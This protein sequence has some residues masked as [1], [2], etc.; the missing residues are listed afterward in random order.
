MARTKQRAQHS[1]GDWSHYPGRNCY[2][3][4]LVPYRAQTLSRTAYRNENLALSFLLPPG[5]SES[6]NPAL[7][8]KQLA[9]ERCLDLSL[10]RTL[11]LE[12]RTR[13]W[14]MVAQEERV[15]S[16]HTIKTGGLRAQAPAILHVCSESRA[17]GLK[18]YCLSFNFD[19]SWEMIE[20]AAR[21]STR[22]SSYFSRV[23]FNFDHDILYFAEGW[24]ENVD[25]EWSCMNHLKRLLD[26]DDMWR[27][28]RI[29][30]DLVTSI[31]CPRASPDEGP[32]GPYLAPWKGLKKLYLGLKDPGLDPNERVVSK[33]LEVEHQEEFLQQ[34]R[35]SPK[36]R[37]VS[38]DLSPEQ[39][40]DFIKISTGRGYGSRFGV[41]QPDLADEF[42]ERV[43]PVLVVNP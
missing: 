22:N 34:Y 37:E 41:I 10:F 17:V 11:P 38:E 6:E 43:C 8:K 39:A 26:L 3:K 33:E 27:V 36:W 1:P 40:L 35:A 18:H 42:C 9:L 28:E 4:N 2:E 29:G 13:I 30:F 32:H 31:C 21:W 23:Y 20:N 7:D 12:M 24:N 15:V 25:G 16:V 14:E 5:P 19:G